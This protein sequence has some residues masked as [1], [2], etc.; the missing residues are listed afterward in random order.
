VSL[1]PAS[2]SGGGTGCLAHPGQLDEAR[3]EVKAG[4]AVN[5]KFTLRRYRAAGAESDN[6]LYLTQ[7]EPNARRLSTGRSIRA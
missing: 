4:L 1:F 6:A 3:S 7:R 2:S 5:P